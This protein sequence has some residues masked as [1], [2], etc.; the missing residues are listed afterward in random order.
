MGIEVEGA[1]L[2][3]AM[4]VEETEGWMRSDGRWLVT[5]VTV[6]LIDDIIDSKAAI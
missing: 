5:G 3:W 6:L 1:A 2:W 4:V